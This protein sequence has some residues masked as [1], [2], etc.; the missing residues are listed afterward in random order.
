MELFDEVRIF[1]VPNTNGEILGGAHQKGEFWVPFHIRNGL[2][3]GAEFAVDLE[4]LAVAQ[5]QAH[6]VASLGYL[7]AIW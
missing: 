1:E 3:V 4:G 7:F 2:V 5:A 6:V